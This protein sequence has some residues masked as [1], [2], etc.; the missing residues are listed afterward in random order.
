MNI[1][2]FSIN[3]IYTY[4]H[5]AMLASLYMIFF[6]IK[7]KEIT[8]L[9]ILPWCVCIMLCQVVLTLFL[10][11][12]RKLQSV[13]YIALAFFAI[14]LFI[15]FK[16]LSPNLSILS[17]IIAIAMWLYSYFCCYSSIINEIS[18]EKLII[19]FEL[20]ILLLIF[21]LFYV[22]FNDISLIYIIPLALSSVLSL[23]SLVI[24][25][26]APRQRSSGD[27]SGIRGMLVIL[28]VVLIIAVLAFLVMALLSEPV[29]E[30][31]AFLVSGVLLGLKYVLYW[32][33]CFF[34][35]LSSLFP[36]D[37]EL[38]SIIE[39]PA[40]SSTS[41]EM[42]AFDFDASFIFTIILIA[43]LVA[44][45]AV[46]LIVVFRGGKLHVKSSVRSDNVVRTRKKLKHILSDILMRIKRKLSFLIN[47]IV[48]RNTAPGLFVWMQK[49]YKPV[50]GQRKKGETC[51]S[52]IM[53]L[54]E[55]FPTLQ[56]QLINFANAL[57]SA[58]FDTSA[59]TSPYKVMSSHEV[60][61]LKKSLK[62]Y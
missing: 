1:K 36:S 60:I 2:R 37:E 6:Y 34:A 7:S 20:S 19:S 31:A 5:I 30:F 28:C 48:H 24:I 46:V 39:D 56:P 12:E 11:K 44:A 14:Q 61:S 32:I 13:A 62:K 17:V 52:Y 29:A 40:S 55:H 50:I 22:S 3:Y 42:E 38:P 15:F 33:R 54:S 8:L 26:T 45:L 57:D 51:R 59:D 25:R 53:R 16:W 21:S 41:S 23:T 35:W 18:F 43:F 4:S 58:Y 47:S 49:R 9:G 27:G 10:K